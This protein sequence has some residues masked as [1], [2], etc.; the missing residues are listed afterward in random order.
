M[1]L[2]GTWRYRRP[3]SIRTNCVCSA[4]LASFLLNEELGHLGR[5]GCALCFIGS[6]IIVLHAPEDKEIETVDEILRLAMQ[7][8]ASSSFSISAASISS[9]P[10]RFP[11][12]LF[13]RPR[14]F[15]G[16]DL[17][18]RTSLWPLEPG[19]VCFHLLSGGLRVCHG[20]QRFR[21]GCKTYLWRQQPIHTFEYICL[22][23]HGRGV[24]SG[25]DE[26]L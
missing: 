25:A 7:P 18:C 5:V 20:H 22:H 13:H 10:T 24:Y 3:K 4:I 11:Y 14:V 1:F 6:L 21:R 17:R 8:G 16:N 26:L 23:D 2:L 12:V 19:R 9:T 15:F